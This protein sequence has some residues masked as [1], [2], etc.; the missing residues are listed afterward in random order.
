MMIKRTLFLALFA[1]ATTLTACDEPGDDL[2]PEDYAALSDDERAEYEDRI[3]AERGDGGTD[4]DASVQDAAAGDLAIE[5]EPLAANPANVAPILSPASS[6]LSSSQCSGDEACRVVVGASAGIRRCV[7][8]CWDDAD[9]NQGEVCGVDNY[10]EVLVKGDWDF[11][12]NGG[13]GRGQG[14]CA[15]DA[16]CT[17]SLLCRQNIG[18]SWDYASGVDVCDYPAGH[19]HYCSSVHP[20]GY[21]QGDCDSN[22]DCNFGLVCKNAR[23][24][25]FGF[26]SWVGVCLYPWQ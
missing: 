9:C 12:V 11:C 24:G 10:C 22:A 26:S 13:C 20:C 16:D 7:G 5:L 25:D 17:G 2:S 23:G 3:E 21:G 18:A 15:V 8:T 19:A 1:T 14:D 4:E 6:C